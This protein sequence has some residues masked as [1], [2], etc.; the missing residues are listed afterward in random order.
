MRNE[1]TRGTKGYVNVSG[2]IVTEKAEN[3]KVGWGNLP[4]MLQ[5]GQVG[6]AGDKPSRGC[7]A[8]LFYHPLAKLGLLRKW[9]HMDT[10]Q[11]W[12]G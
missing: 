9:L 11:G 2:Q 4:E 3:L 5:R 8:K 6:E 1:F 10:G 12:V 7:K